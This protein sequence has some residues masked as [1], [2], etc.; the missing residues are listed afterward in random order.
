MDAAVVPT[1][2][3]NIVA[4]IVPVVVTAVAAAAVA[5]LVASVVNAVMTTFVAAVVPLVGKLATVPHKPHC[6]RLIRKYHLTSAP[7]TSNAQANKSAAPPDV[8]LSA[9]ILQLTKKMGI[10]HTRRINASNHREGTCVR[11]TMTALS[12][13]S[14][15][16]RA[17]RCAQDLFKV[18]F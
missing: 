10:A 5:A 8:A 17:R 13:K 7:M 11:P 4:G 9:P 6:A 14:A 3:A 12:Y 16:A 15:A 1:M 2:E 18:T